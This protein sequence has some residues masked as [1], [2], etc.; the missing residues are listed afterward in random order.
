MLKIPVPVEESQVA[1]AQGRAQEL[2][3]PSS[4][5]AGGRRSGRR[6]SVSTGLE[7]GIDNFFRQQRH[8]PPWQPNGFGRPGP[9]FHG[10][11]PPFHW[12]HR[13]GFGPHSFRPPPPPSVYLINGLGGP[14]APLSV[15]PI[16][17][18]A[19]QQHA[20][21]VTDHQVSCNACR[22]PIISTRWLC[23]NCPTD[24]T[25]N[26][27]SDCEKSSHH[28]DPMHAFIRIVYPLRKPLPRMHALIP[29]V[30]AP[31]ALIH[32]HD[33]NGNEV[34]MGTFHDANSI[35]HSNVI[36]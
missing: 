6:T 9:P 32:R 22:L 28:H 24:A 19:L 10:G 21:T 12:G 26:L 13:G 29:I 4:S 7:N 31:P 35:A 5:S 20:Q 33:S 25:Y 2:A 23:A 34:E 17:P 18:S 36:W 11:G 14:S 30:Y 8:P 1:D 15:Q 27:C 16:D 3:N